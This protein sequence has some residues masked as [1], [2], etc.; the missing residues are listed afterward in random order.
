MHGIRAFGALIALAVLCV[1]AAHA[2][3]LPF[4]LGQRTIDIDGTPIEVYTYKPEGYSDGPLLVTF[5]G[6]GRHIEPYLDAAKSIADRHGMLVVLPLFDR[7]RFPY[8]RYQGLGIARQSRR[9]ASGPLP[10]KPRSEWTSELIVKLIDR[11]RA[12]EGSPNVDYYLMGHSAGGQIANRLAA[13]TP[14]HAKRIVVTNPSSYVAATRLAR[15]PYGFGDLPAELSDDAALR[16]YLAQPITIFLGTADV[17]S[18]DLDVLPPAMR[19]GSTRHER[20]LNVFRAA[21]ALARENGWPFNWSLVEVPDVGHDVQRMFR[22]P[23]SSAAL[24][25]K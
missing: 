11:I 15:F 12:D 13:F 21:Q 16:R 6:L 1:G 10:V 8:W 2:E 7:K 5:H 17:L 3:P 24:F 22:S 18:R 4:G 14:N 25:G 20:G 19:Q 9:V 23:Q